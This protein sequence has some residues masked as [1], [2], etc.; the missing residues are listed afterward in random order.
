MVTRGGLFEEQLRAV[1]I[2]GSGIVVSGR[3][4]LDPEGR[5]LL[6]RLRLQLPE[7]KRPVFALARSVRTYGY[8]EALRFVEISDV[9]RLSIA[10]HMD[11]VHRRGALLD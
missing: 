11:V 10:E 5:P 4:I 7:K 6:V 2:S 9:D 1:E 3:T 8:Q